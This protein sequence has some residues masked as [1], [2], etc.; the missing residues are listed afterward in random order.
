MSQGNMPMTDA[1]FRVLVGLLIFLASIVAAVWF[2]SSS[3][4][5][6]ASMEMEPAECVEM[7][8]KAIQRDR[9]F[10]NFADIVKECDA[11]FGQGCKLQP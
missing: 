4:P 6:R 11:R 2:T 1:G 10:P 3:A 7:C 8:I 5:L 9:V